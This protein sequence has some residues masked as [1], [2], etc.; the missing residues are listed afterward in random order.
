MYY[1]NSKKKTI[2]NGNGYLHS[3]QLIADGFV[4]HFEASYV[5]RSA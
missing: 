5:S 3:P 4:D 2:S 1:T